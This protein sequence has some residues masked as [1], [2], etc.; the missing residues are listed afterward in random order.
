MT[1]EKGRKE[2]LSI[3]G[4]SVSASNATTPAPA[5]D[6]ETWLGA[7]VSRQVK[8]Q[9]R[10]LPLLYWI[11]VIPS[12]RFPPWRQMPVGTFDEVVCLVMA[13]KTARAFLARQTVEAHAVHLSATDTLVGV[14]QRDS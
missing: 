14:A 7:K 4:T 5:L 13:W 10:H 2:G 12:G 1:A 3:L 9:T 8:S 11:N 6:L